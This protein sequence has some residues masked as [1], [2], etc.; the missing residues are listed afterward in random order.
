[1]DDAAR[2]AIKAYFFV[3]PKW[4]I[5]FLVLTPFIIFAAFQDKNNACGGMG[6][7]VI[8][9]VAVA[10][11]LLWLFRG[12][13]ARPRD[14]QMD[15]WLS[16]DLKF[17]G[18]RALQKGGVD[19]SQVVREP[20]V[21]I[22]PRFNA[23]GGA[24]FGIRKGADQKIRFTPVDVTVINFA[25]HQL[26][27]YQ[28]AFDRTTGSPLNE[29]T[30]EYFYKDVVSAATQAQSLSFSKQDIGKQVLRRVSAFSEAA[31]GSVQ[32]N[33]ADTFT[34]TTS[35]GTSV[36]VVISDRAI[37]Q[38]LG[39]GSLPT[40]LADQAVQAVRSMLRDKKINAT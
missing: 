12:L 3:V 7:S 31:G 34:L 24:F 10:A 9:L 39:G 17:V 29:G 18:V 30:A 20:V 38:A 2:R 4:L 22:G 1:V 19:A 36:R 33:Q 14:E 16:E 8:L 21:V 37:V 13:H 28:C 32:L 15:Q 5:I 6:C 27:T 23:R 40:E 25:Q 26:L 11:A 35:G